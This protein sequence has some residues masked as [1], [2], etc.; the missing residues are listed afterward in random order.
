MRMARLLEPTPKG[1]FCPAG[2]FHI[3]PWQP[4]ERAVLTHAHGDHAR[5][6]SAQY[7]CASDGLELARERI[8]PEARIDSIPYGRATRVG[9]ALVS[10]HPAGHIL[11]S[12]QVRI[13]VA[14]EVWVVSGD[15][16]RQPDPTCAP[17]EPIRCHA[18]VTESTFALPI[19]RWRDPRA[20]A[21]DIESWWRANQAEGRT[22]LMFA[23]AVG[24][25]QRILAS[26]DASIGPI[27]VHGSVARFNASYRAAGVRLPETLPADAENAKRH[28]G[29]ALV[30]A[31]PIAMNSPWARKFGNAST[32]FASGWMQI[33]GARRRKNVD[34]GFA[35]SDHADWPGLVDTIRETGAERVF[36]THGSS[37]V[38]ARWLRE[39]GVDAN[40]WKTA[41]EGE[42]GAEESGAVGAGEVD[43][44]SGSDAETNDA[45]TSP[46]TGDAE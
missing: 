32:A 7:L 8:G 46:R 45:G 41:W 21:D 27:L 22:S 16:K 2:R 9:N 42:A 1:L 17:F 33:R 44:E 11:G 39:Q 3:D 38:L 14:G 15:F 10:L 12:A 31:P 23:Y 43:S 26:I 13:E 5:A 36:A 40:V 25:A 35:L 19:Y 6:G 29:R 18:F 30:I 4:V 34:R 28:K 24:K 37:D 20:I